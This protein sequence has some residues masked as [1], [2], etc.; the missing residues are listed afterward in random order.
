MKRNQSVS[1]LNNKPYIRLLNLFLKEC[2]FH[3]GDK[4]EIHY[5][6]NE[7]TIKK[8]VSNI[9]RFSNFNLLNDEG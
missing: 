3:I 8:I 7:L 1:K 9:D 6:H 5:F 4:I 2:N